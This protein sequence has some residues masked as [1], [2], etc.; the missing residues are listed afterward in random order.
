MA[1]MYD[2]DAVILGDIDRP[3]HV[4][5][6]EEREDR[7]DAL[8]HEKVAERLVDRN[9]HDGTVLVFVLI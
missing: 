8:L 5:V 7:V 6:A 9:F 3:M 1:G 4:G 2:P